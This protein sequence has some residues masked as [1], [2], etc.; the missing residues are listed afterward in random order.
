MH[1]YVFACT[2]HK[3]WECELLLDPCIQMYK[4]HSPPPQL[5]SVQDAL[6]SEWQEIGVRLLSDIDS[7]ISAV[8]THIANLENT[9]VSMMVGVIWGGLAS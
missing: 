8:H 7:R 9:E 5:Q 6:V 4:S 2:T 1:L 3:P